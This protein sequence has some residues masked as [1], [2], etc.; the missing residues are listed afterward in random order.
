MSSGMAVRRDRSV[1]YVLNWEV[2]LMWNQS[3]ATFCW[4]RAYLHLNFF[5]PSGWWRGDWAKWRYVASGGPE[6]VISTL[7]EPRAYAPPWKIHPG[8]CL[9]E[10]KYCASGMW[11]QRTTKVQK[12]WGKK[13]KS[14]SYIKEDPEDVFVVNFRREGEEQRRNPAEGERCQRE[15]QRAGF[16]QSDRYSCA[17]CLL[18]LK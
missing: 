1:H 11:K 8:L 7:G 17:V 10:C 15:T 18:A 12:T 2:K 6:E 5:F 13:I 3:T 9:G 16:G 4:M 14:G